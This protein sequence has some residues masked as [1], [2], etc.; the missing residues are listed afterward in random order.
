MGRTKLN[1]PISYPPSCKRR[2]DCQGEGRVTAQG[3]R[4]TFRRSTFGR[5]MSLVAP[6]STHQFTV[7]NTVFEVRRL[8]RF[9]RQ[10]PKV[11]PV[12]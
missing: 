11:S 3:G 9:A 4:V 12:A 2:F 6:D 7:S 8:P 10:P 1:T 5:A